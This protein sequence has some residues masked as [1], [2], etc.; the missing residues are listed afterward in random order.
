MQQ[1]VVGVVTVGQAPRPDLEREFDQMVTGTVL[2][3]GALDGISE[4]AISDM[5]SG[6]QD[7]YPIRCALASGQEVSVSKS[8]LMPLVQQRVNELAEA[9]AT[10]VVIGCNS[11]FEPIRAKVPVLSPGRIV[12]QMVYDLVGDGRLG[13]MVPLAQQVPVVTAELAAKGV[14][15]R[16]ERASPA[17]SEAH[18]LGL[19]AQLQKDGC[20]LIFLRCFGFGG[21]WQ[22]AVAAH[23]GL[24]V[25]SPVSISASLVRAIIG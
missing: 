20:S 10:M 21:D 5:Q 6:G 4:R 16:V 25:I 8:R 12:N 1:P 9:G 3:R 23:T 22:R 14:L 17:D 18:V 19:A 15:G 24:P 13:C 11:T 7:D 2:I